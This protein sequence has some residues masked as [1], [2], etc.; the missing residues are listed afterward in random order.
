MITYILMRIAE[1]QY[2]MFGVMIDDQNIPFV[3]TLELPWMQNQHDI[4]CIPN[5]T[6]K[7]KRVETEHHGIVFQI[8]NVHN[9][10]GILIH[11]GNLI[12]DSKG[13]VLIGEQ[14]EPINGLPGISASGAGFAEFM[15]KLKD[16]DEFALRIID[17]IK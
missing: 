2:G 12:K 8:M 5:G 15:E 13:C 10:S 14:F 11:W 3:L 1:N 17:V 6:Y 7:V 4:S 16:V 9:R